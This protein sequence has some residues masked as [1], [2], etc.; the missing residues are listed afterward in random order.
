MAGLRPRLLPQEL[1]AAATPDLPWRRWILGL[2]PV[3]TLAARIVAR[4]QYGWVRRPPDQPAGPF[5]S[6]RVDARATSASG[7]PV[8]G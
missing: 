3:G 8:P 6:S 7:C 5:A 2:S 1:P 4:F